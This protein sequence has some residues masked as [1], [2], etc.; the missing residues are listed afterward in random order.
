MVPSF[1]LARMEMMIEV[2]GD[3]RDGLDNSGG[4]GGGHFG[5]DQD[6]SSESDDTQ[7]SEFN[8]VIWNHIFIPIW[9]NGDLIFFFIELQPDWISW[10][11]IR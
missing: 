2:E 8:E 10:R 4:G 1:A 9:R 5:L 11:Y 6:K 3:P 7:H